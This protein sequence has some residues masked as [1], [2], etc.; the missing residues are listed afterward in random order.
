MTPRFCF[1][2]P[3]QMEM[4]TCNKCG[5]TKQNTE[6]YPAKKGR[7]GVT[8]VCKLCIGIQNR[9]RHAVKREE[10]MAKKRSYNAEHS[11]ERVIKMA[12]WRKRNPAKY[13][14]QNLKRL[15]GL[16][17]AEFEKMLAA[18]GGCCAI[19][20]EKI[21]PIAEGG[22]TRASA[23]VDHDHATATVRAILC[24]GCNTGLGCF[25]DD[26]ALLTAAARYL[27]QHSRAEA[28]S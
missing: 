22:R 23:C 18:Q 6:F 3:S 1:S 27:E 7:G 11:P 12:D 24:R 8:A 25:D 19:C 2:P 17:L 5:E 28:V 9:A 10:R 20:S 21:A 16:E 13:K 26:P 4:K 15:Y 14:A